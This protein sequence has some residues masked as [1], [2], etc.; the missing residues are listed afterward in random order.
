MSGLSIFVTSA[1]T[2]AVLGATAAASGASEMATTSPRV[3][4]STVI[5]ITTP[6]AN[7][8]DSM[9]K[10]IATPTGFLVTFARSVGSVPPFSLF[11]QR[12]SATGIAVGGPVRFDLGTVGDHAVMTRT[13]PTT[14][15]AAWMATGQ[16]KVARVD[17]TTGAVTGARLIGK[18]DDHVHDVAALDNRNIAVVTPQVDA[19]ARRYKVALKILSPTLGTVREWQSVNGVGFPLDA[20]AYLDQTV[21]ARQGGGIVLYRDHATNRVMGRNFDQSGALGSLVQVSTTA[22][23]PFQVGDIAYLE[24]K[25]ARLTNGKVAACWVA[26]QAVFANRYDVRCRLIGANGVPVGTDFLASA[27]ALK[28]Q[29]GPEVTALPGGR[30]T[31]QWVHM[32][33]FTALVRY[34]T[35][36]ANGATAAP[37]FAE[38]TGATASAFTTLPQ[39]IE[40]AALA[41]G[42]IATVLSQDTFVTGLRAFGIARPAQ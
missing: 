41:D 33:A 6:P 16:V 9:H 10:V 37:L 34:R 27:S 35:Y 18:S 24:V 28:P 32:E 30:F 11:T 17:L 13:G 22:F 8:I 20:W 12:Y 7:S 40:A 3:I 19:L 21:V 38:R 42:S 4:A 26:T 2:L 25:A 1:A 5:K 23:S 36:D 39:Q 31:V 15:V 14:A 29:F